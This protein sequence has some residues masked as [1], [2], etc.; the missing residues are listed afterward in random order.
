[1]A[2]EKQA[3][4]TAADDAAMAEMAAADNDPPEVEAD[5]PAEPEQD[6]GDKGKAKKGDDK[7][8]TVDIRALHQARGETKAEREA[9]KAAE[10]RAERMERRYDEM[11]RRLAQPPK[12]EEDPEPP[13][14]DTAP[15]DW[16]RW[17]ARRKDKAI[18]ELSTWKQNQE[19][20]GQASAAD[21]ELL[22]NTVAA[23]QE[24]AATN[25]DYPAAL[26]HAQQSRIQFFLA[27]GMSR[28]EAM[29]ALHEETKF[30]A[31]MAIQQGKNPAERV[32]AIAKSL[33]YKPGA[34]K[35]QSGEEKVEQLARGMQGSSK[36]A[37]G[38]DSGDGLSLKALADIE[39]DAEFDKLWEQAKK[40]GKLG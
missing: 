8:K 9:R 10:A 38:G 23:E 2:D 3:S 28:A 22:R 30:V 1:M 12:T 29:Q 37:G 13:N 16:L 31:R 11:Q 24:F 34:Q 4:D 21:A 17:D 33:G 6:D 32:Y 14:F 35:P 18:A 5:E 40:S 20:G 7:P 25:P 36:M 26:A 27:T 15:A 39:D 19:R